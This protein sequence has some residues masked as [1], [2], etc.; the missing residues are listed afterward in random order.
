MTKLLLVGNPNTGKTTLFNTITNKNNKVGNWHGITVSESESK[1][2]LGG[3]SGV[4]VDLPGIYSLNGYSPE[5]KLACKY[6]FEHKD[7]KTICICDANSL[8]RNLLLAIELKN[9]G[10][11]VVVAMNMAKE[12]KI[13]YAKLSKLL[14]LQIIEIDARKKKS[15]QKLVDAVFAS[16]AQD[17]CDNKTN[18]SIAQIFARIDGMLAMVD[19]PQK[20]YGTS[21]LDKFFYNKFLAIPI[22]LLVMLFIF[23]LTFG[24]IGSFLTSLASNCFSVLIDKINDGLIKINISPWAH[25]LI[26]GGILSG[27]GV[28][29]GFLPQIILLNLCLS[30]LEDL[31]YLSRVAFMFDGAL[32]KVGLSGKSVMSILLGLGCTA[33]AMLTTRALDSEKKRKHT[34]LVIPFASCNAKL[35][36][37]LLICSAFFAKYKVLIVFAMY[38][39]SIII[40]IFVSFVA[41]RISR[42]KNE[43]FVMEMP[44]IRWQ[45]PT[46]TLKNAMFACLD[47]LRRVG[48]SIILC[49]VFV[50]VLSNI[51]FSFAYADKIEKSILYSI[52]KF[53]CPIFAPMGLNN[54]GAVVAL[55]TG[56]SAK[57]MVVASLSI[58]NGI[59]GDLNMLASSLASPQSMVHFTPAS[60][61][62]FLIFVLLYSPCFSA[63]IVTSKELGKKF[64]CFVFFFQFA[65]A[66]AA[67]MLT[68]FVASLAMSGKIFEIISI[69]IVLALIIL[70]VLKY[71]RKKQTCMACKGKCYGAVYCTRK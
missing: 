68:Y 30:F 47:F 19:Y 64:A 66:Y 53:I 12:V 35:P 65:L 52:S 10:L 29:I 62:S 31:G 33:S 17:S 34:A 48:A 46:K 38:L 25:S 22:F 28:L 9:A 41:S 45:S 56:L 54:R 23:W 49:S 42:D 50:W 4:L 39:V 1:F 69:F 7:C 21:K 18:L 15:A 43:S 67:S 32:K 24:P 16:R 2:S 26:T 55:L 11:N 70:V 8:R 27:A 20:T 51:T 6:I 61:L 13:D 40:G 57:E 36:I 59:V 5:E 58:S 37:Y 63:I 14:G 3:K 60:A 71:T 44:P